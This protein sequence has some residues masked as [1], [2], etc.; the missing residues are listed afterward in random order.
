LNEV[1]LARPR[2][3]FGGEIISVSPV[4]VPRIIGKNGSML[5]VLKKGTG[6]NVMVGRNGRIWVKGGNIPLLVK[7]IEKIETEAHLNNLTN[8]VGEFLDAERKKNGE[9]IGEAVHETIEKLVETNHK[10]IALEE[11]EEQMDEEGAY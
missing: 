6:S 11:E 5:E 7:A 8:R 1:D 10:K 2:I 4:K 9:S 3:F